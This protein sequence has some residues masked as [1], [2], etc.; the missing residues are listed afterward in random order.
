M[1][2]PGCLE[3]IEQRLPSCQRSGDGGIREVAVRYSRSI[4][5]TVGVFT[6]VTVG[7]RYDRIRVRAGHVMPR[8]DYRTRRPV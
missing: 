6:M 1:S 2:M 7:G 8:R 5:R 3:G 4:G